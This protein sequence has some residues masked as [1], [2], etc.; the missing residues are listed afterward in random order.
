MTQSL[1]LN[2]LPIFFC[3]LLLLIAPSCGGSDALPPGTTLIIATN[4]DYP[5][6]GYLEEGGSIAGF[7]YEYGVLLCEELEVECVWRSAPFEETVEGV[8]KGQ[9]DL[10][11]N[12]LTQTEEQEASVSFSDPYYRAYAQ[13]IRLSGSDADLS[14]SVTVSTHADS[15][16]SF[17][18]GIPEFEHVR[19]LEFGSLE[20]IIAAVAKGHADLAMVDDVIADLLIDSPTRIP[21]ELETAVFE[22]VGGPIIPTPGSVEEQHLGTGNIG[23]IVP[24]ANEHLLPE[25]NRA[26]RK[27]NGGE[28]VADISKDYFGRNIVDA[29]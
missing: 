27:V 19:V 16:F 12:S 13:L 29:E 25:I 2:S 7:D 4:N 18:L 23:V 3:A 22:R 11:V 28:T 24:K 6:F 26:I 5:P 8:S 10:A 20:N 21:E 9:Y 14:G 15:L 17:Y 1:Y